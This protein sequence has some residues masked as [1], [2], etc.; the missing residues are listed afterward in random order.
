MSLIQTAPAAAPHSAAAAF[1]GLAGA[2]NEKTVAIAK[3]GDV[4]GDLAVNAVIALL[5]F[6]GAV[7]L[8]KWAAN[9]VRN[10]LKRLPRTAHD[11][12]LQDFAGSITRYAILVIGVVAILRRLGVETTSIITVLG[13]ASLAIGLALQ[14]ALSNV[15]AG[16]MI[17]LFRPY[18]VG[19]LV[20][21][22]GKLGTVKRFDL[23]NTELADV[24]GLKLTVP[25]GKA[26]GDV[27]TNYT[28]IPNRRVEMTF[29]LAPDA[30]ADAAAKAALAV[31]LADPRV[32]DTPEPM[33]R[34][35]EYT[36][37][38]I[39]LTVRA[40]AVPKDYWDMRFDLSK[41][42]TQAVVKAGGALYYPT[43]RAV[44]LA[45]PSEPVA[46]PA[47]IASLQ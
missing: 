17:L 4:L 14:G 1:T 35:T 27:A 26:F 45:G 29:A 9:L 31:L 38:K 25:N 46:D 6:F 40:W 15:A 5:I 33:S 39:V 42:V 8:S 23:F 41:L 47:S 18:R 32:L 30:D 21:I 16:V 12:T 10:T 3:A 7:W 28:D 2:V 22:A 36:A 11:R 20:S 34:A 37:E 43:Q 44:N 24:D 13:A 19:D